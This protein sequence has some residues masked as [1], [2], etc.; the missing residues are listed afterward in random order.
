MWSPSGPGGR[1]DG[2]GV[3]GGGQPVTAKVYYIISRQEILDLFISSYIYAT[4]ICTNKTKQNK[5]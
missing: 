5:Q 4:L 2:V 1:G 3:G